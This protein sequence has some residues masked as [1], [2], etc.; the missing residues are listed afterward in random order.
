MM[1][2]RPVLLSLALFFPGLPHRFETP[3]DPPHPNR[4]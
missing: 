4:L 2:K 1:R 3:I